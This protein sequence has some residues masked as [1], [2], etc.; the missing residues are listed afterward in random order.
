VG[1]KKG[2]NPVLKDRHIR[3]T[4]LFLCWSCRWE[5]AA[6]WFTLPAKAG[7]KGKIRNFWKWDHTACELYRHLAHVFFM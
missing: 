1:K 3:G 2:K 7:K 4:R 6:N 5:C